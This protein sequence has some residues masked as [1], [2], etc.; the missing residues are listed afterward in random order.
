MTTH[1]APGPLDAPSR[2]ADPAHAGQGGPD[3]ARSLA[4]PATAD[5]GHSGPGPS[6]GSAANT[7]VGT[8][9]SPAPGSS[10]PAVAAPPGGDPVKALMHRHRELCARAVDPLEIAAAL[11]AHGMTDRTA[12]RFR[13]RDVF[14]LAEEMYARVPR[15]SS[16]PPASAHAAPEPVAGSAAGAGPSRL[17]TLVLLP[18]L[19]GALCA[20]LLA[21]LAQAPPGRARTLAVVTG[22]LAVLSAVQLCL[23]HGPL[24]SPRPAGV[25]VRLATLWLLGYAVLGDGLLDAAVRGGPDRLWPVDT[26]TGLGLALAMWPAVLCAR[27]FTGGARR[28]L[29]RSRGLG[30][31]AAATRPLLLASLTCYLVALGGLL[32]L[33]GAL[34]GASPA[35]AGAG[36]LGALL[37][38]ARLL[39]VHGHRATPTVALATAA[40]VELAVLCSVL[41]SRL[42]GCDVL[43]VPAETL[44]EVSGA[45][46]V[47]TL[48]CAVAAFAL[49]V[50][51][52]PALSRASAHTD[53]GTR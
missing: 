12:A 23:R 24:R 4:G 6:G 20:G 1:R 49:L 2:P 18:A 45:A 19:P 14:S 10:G 34:L 53:P 33:A 29:V 8:G 48:A 37:L 9:D 21:G 38:L 52:V 26:A 28:R 39:L 46:A 51:A 27:I 3:P 15:H 16:A 40:G 43:A 25:A 17:L 30:E 13:H 47:P 41:A 50:R 44:I 7:A 5:P 35:L 36:A 31:F 11:E 22:V 42:P 32:A